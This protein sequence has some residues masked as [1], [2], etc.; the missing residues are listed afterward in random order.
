MLPNKDS[1]QIIPTDYDS[2]EMTVLDQMRI[3]QLK[4]QIKFNG[5][6]FKFFI[7][8]N[9][10]Y[11]SSYDLVQKHNKEIRR[12]IRKFYKYDIK[13]IFFIERSE[14]GSYHRHFLVEDLPDYRWEHQRGRIKNWLDPIDYFN[15]LS[16]EGLP[17]SSKIDLLNR[18]IRNLTFISNGK[19]ALDIRPIHNLD[20]LL[21]YC[22]KQFEV[23]HPSHEV[24]DSASTERDID[25]G[26]IF[27]TNRSVISGTQDFVKMI[28]HTDQ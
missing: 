16:G 14:N 26:F 3:E 11:Y 23:H 17:D 25:L 27:T 13:M 7:S 20:K 15:C 4:K 6:K 8:N 21:A 9:N 10:H 28:V 12:S 24:I 19:K 22:T 2:Y 1:S 5:Y 18:V